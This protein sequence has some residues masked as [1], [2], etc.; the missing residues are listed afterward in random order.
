MLALAALLAQ[1][2]HYKQADAPRLPDGKVNLTAPAPKSFDGRPDLS[3]VWENPGWREGAAAGGS[4]SGTG[5]APGSRTEATRRPQ[6][7]LLAAFFELG[8]MVPGGLPYQPWAKALKD[9]RTKDNAKDNPDAHCLP[10][11]NMQLHL[12]PEPRKIIH[13]KNEIVILYEGNG[14]VRQIFTDG[15]AL[16]AGD[17]QP[18]WFGY[19]IGK[20][21]GETLVVQT[22]GFRDGGWLDVNG[23][24]LTD[25]GKMTE[26]FRRINYGTLELELTVDDAKAYTKPFTVKYNQRLMPDD[27][28]IEFVC[29]ENERSSAH[30]K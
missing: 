27:E 10:L 21:E 29:Q 28:L 15:R 11:G 6:M 4:V 3:G 26:R 30:F 25:Q 19:S 17:P 1:W 22:S 8:S 14:G 12:H 23:S 13:G 2:P 24:P 9:Q 18:W 16:P 5:G 7:P 20:W